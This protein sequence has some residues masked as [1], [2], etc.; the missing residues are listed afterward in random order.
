M[1]K[2]ESQSIVKKNIRHVL[3]DDLA[4]CE[5]M[6]AVL[7]EAARLSAPAI[8]R[9]LREDRFSAE[10]LRREPLA[11]LPELPRTLFAETPDA[12]LPLT[13]AKLAADAGAYL[14]AFAA[15]VTAELQAAKLHPSPSMFVAHATE[16]MPLRVA[17]PDTAA[18]RRAAA[19]LAARVGDFEVS[20]VRSFADAADAVVGGDCAYCMLPL[21]NSRDG[22][23]STT[24]RMMTESGLFVTR[25]CACTDESGVVTRFALLCREGDALP[26]D[27][28]VQLA[29]RL[30]LSDAA[31]LPTL[32]TA[33]A[34]LGVTLVRTASQ[35]LGYTDGYA[36]LCTFGGTREALFA[37]LL[38]LALAGQNC[39]L[40]GVYGTVTAD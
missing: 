39:M 30:S 21:E 7:D 1:A 25:V 16:A 4:A 2:S 35:P 17:V 14:A 22:F 19:A 9:M 8:V 37:W 23:L 10:T 15:R 34:A 6:S 36:Q 38:L 13:A 18:F 24:L 29:L 3:A 11:C 33:M 28:D 31:A 5:R 26:D 12:N 32:F 40:L 20:P 27:G